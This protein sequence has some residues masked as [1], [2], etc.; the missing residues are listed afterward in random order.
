LQNH[1]HKKHTHIYLIRHGETDWNVAKRF[2][3]Q[4]DVPLNNNG[5]HQAHAVTAWLTRQDMAFN[6]IYSSDLMRCTQ[7]ADPIGKALKL[8]IFT[9]ARLREIHCGEWEGSTAHTIDS[10]T[11]GILTRWRQEA[12]TFRMPGGENVSDVVVRVSAFYEE[13]IVKHL[14]ENIIIIAHGGS[15][16]ALLIAIEGLNI[17]QAWNDSSRRIH[18]T[19]VSIL[20]L[21]HLT[22]THDVLQFNL[23]EH[24]IQV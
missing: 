10:K 1:N 13:T 2:Q 5:L 3:G 16:A 19:G 14:G 6:A 23:L 4:S 21:D 24:L 15:I 12:D 22:G 7:T 20:S 8:D 17:V 9:D 18:N 11:P